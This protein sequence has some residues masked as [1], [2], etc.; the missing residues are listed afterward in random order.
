MSWVNN[1]NTV[2]AQRFRTDF[3]AILLA[4]GFS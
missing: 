2:W 1:D 3:S 4:V